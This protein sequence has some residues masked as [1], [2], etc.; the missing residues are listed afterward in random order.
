VIRRIAALFVLVY[1]LGYAV[2][3]L[4]LPRPADERR[5][6]AIVVLTGAAGRIDRGLDLLEKGR[7]LR[8]LISGVARTVRPVELAAQTGRDQE[9]FRCCIDLG[10]ESVDTR[11]NAEE[12]ARWLQHH[13]FKTVRLVTT[14]WHMPRASFEL[15]RRAGSG[16][17]I[18]EDAIPSDPKFRQL[19]TEYNKYLLRRAAILIGV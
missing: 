10:R 11:S 6:D 13:R 4:V 9:L 17:E 1:A 3:V 2:F 16:I 19:F 8:M 12:T 15:S 5:T 7:A 14:D 18:V